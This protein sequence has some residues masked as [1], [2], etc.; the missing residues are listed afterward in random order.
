M[1]PMCEN[2]QT[3]MDT[4]TF[5]RS[6]SGADEKRAQ[7]DIDIQNTHTQCGWDLRSGLEFPS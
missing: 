6:L 4:H 7:Q 5:P 2:T 3:P 1:L